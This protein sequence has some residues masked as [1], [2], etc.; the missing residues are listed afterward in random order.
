L[1][2]HDG[3][4]V[5]LDFEYFGWDDPA[6]MVSDFL[7]HPAMEL[8]D[9]L[10]RRFLR[11]VAEGFYGYPELAGRIQ[12]LYPVF[13]LKWCLILLN[14]FA[15][16]HLQRRVFASDVPLDPEEVRSEQLSKSRHMLQRVL[17][18]YQKFPYQS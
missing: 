18:E 10:R 7:L 2:L 16:E 12:A 14:E 4:I 6:K 3:T 13:G 9:R 8:D 17:D 11:G 15:T 5:F 1:R